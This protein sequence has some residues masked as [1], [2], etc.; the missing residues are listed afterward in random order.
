MAP[1]IIEATIFTFEKVLK[2]TTTFAPSA[3]RFHYQFNF[4]ELARVVEGLCRST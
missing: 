1:K 3:K 2:N 4:R